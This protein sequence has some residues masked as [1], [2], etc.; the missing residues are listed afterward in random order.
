[1][2]FF[3]Q[4]RWLSTETAMF[5]HSNPRVFPILPCVVVFTCIENFL[6]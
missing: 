1:M 4:Q 6:C 3:E 2:P 5:S